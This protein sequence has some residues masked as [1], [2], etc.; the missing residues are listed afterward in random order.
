V[1]SPS[2][3]RLLEKL[4]ANSKRK[5][6]R[7]ETITVSSLM[8]ARTNLKSADKVIAAIRELQMEGLL[9]LKEIIFEGRHERELIV[10]SPLDT[11]N[12][13]LGQG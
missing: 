1:S 12:L 3:Q 5:R 4:Q 10:L 2:A 13:T 11:P 7:H 8:A 9:E 6:G